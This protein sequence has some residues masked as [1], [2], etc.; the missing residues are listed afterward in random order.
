M[1]LGL[2]W[3]LFYTVSLI[4]LALVGSALVGISIGQTGAISY[5]ALLAVLIMLSGLAIVVL[6][7][8]GI[9]VGYYAWIA[10]FYV[11]Y[12]SVP[13]TEGFRLHPLVAVLASLFIMFFVQRVLVERKSIN[14]HIPT[15]YWGFMIFWVWGWV[16]GSAGNFKTDVMLEHSLNFVWVILLFPVTN[17]VLDTDLKRR[18]VTIAFIGVG[19]A[20]GLMGLIE[21]YFPAVQNLLPSFV[22]APTSILTITTYQGDTFF[23]RAQFAF[24]GHPVASFICLLAFPLL[25]AV[26]NWYPRPEVYAASAVSAVIL[27]LA[28]YIGGFRSAW[29]ITG[30][31]FLIIAVLRRNIF[32]FI[33]ILGVLWGIQAYFPED[34]VTRALTA[35]SALEGE[36]QD[37]SAYKRYNR[38][39]DAIA[40]IEAHPEGQ[41]WSSSG[42]V[43]NDL[44]QLAA[45][46]SVL[47]AI[48]FAAIYMRIIGQIFRAYAQTHNYFLLGL[49]GSL[50]TS[51]ILF[52]T[53]PIYVL[54]QLVMPIWFI[55]ALAENVLFNLEDDE[56]I[57]ALESRV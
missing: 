28:I 3:R 8:W 12:R 53:Q 29:G 6:G 5:Q 36:F 48:L 38:I 32:V 27:L 42:W 25:I 11:G 30:L 14:L 21:Y 44:V 40:Q 39:Q 7:R 54:P 17:Y 49:L 55:W 18:Y 52:V 9:Q 2:E 34:G 47:G 56:S 10:L 50:V 57:S 13:M 45:D 26:V 51:A 15:L 46:T 1:I 24:F 41:G 4:A 35:T 43:H 22:G 37:G 20:I 16:Q 31:L 23:R 19:T 33:A